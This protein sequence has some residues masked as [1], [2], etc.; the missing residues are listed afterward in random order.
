MKRKPIKTVFCLALTAL[1]SSGGIVGAAAVEE[2]GGETALPSSYSSRDMGYVTSVKYQDYSSCWAFAAM[3][4][5]E[6]FLLRNGEN[7]SDMST[8]HLNM[9]A[10]PRES[11]NGWQRSV[12]SDGYPNIALGYMTSWQGGVLQ[13][14][15]GDYPLS[16]EITGDMVPVDL[17]RYG[18]TSVRYLQKGDFEEIKRA[19]MDNGGVYTS[20]A[21][22]ASCLNKERTAY[23]MPESYSGGYSGHSI[24]V[25]GWDDN[26]PRESFENE[27][28]KLPVGNGAWLIKNSWGNNNA[29]GGY[30]WASYEDKYLFSNKYNPS[31]SLQSYEKLDG[32]VK[33]IQNEIY[34]A[35]YEFKYVEAPVLTYINRLHFD[36][37]FNV[38]DKVVFKTDA[39]GADY[40]IW[41]VPDG[42]GEAPDNDVSHWTRLYDGAVDYKGYIC[43]DIE[44]FAY[45]DSTG[46]I[47]VT[48]DATDSDGKSSLG[49]GE[50]LTNSSD[51]V[52]KNES[53]KGESYLK[54]GDDMQDLMDWYLENE[55]D[56]IGGTFVIKAVTKQYYPATLLGDVNQ[57]GVVNILD[58][59]EIQRHVAEYITLEKTALANADINGDGIITIEDGTLLQMKLALLI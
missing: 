2:N 48:V 39:V 17:A 22:S 46:S 4:T 32:K 50:W 38:I 15:L 54:N 57:D 13:S 25:V 8:N 37:D 21:H 26:Y 27:T 16:N 51:Y 42:T 7:I 5:L 33:L 34:G 9:W 11:G 36:G 19:V 18:I 49:V 44:D 3:A 47:A 6:S 31:Y 30:F 52:F 43:A 23:Y 53:A 28:G 12:A 14:D 29:L 24:E 20:Y 40:T 41:Y 35:T 45:P 55:D 58:V 56:P 1:I 10:T 59:T